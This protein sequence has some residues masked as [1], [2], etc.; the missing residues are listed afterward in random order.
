MIIPY[1]TDAPVYYFPF[2]TIATIATNIAFYFLFC[3]GIQDGTPHPFILDFETINPLQWLTSIFM[4]AHLLH[5]IGN[6]VFLWSY[7]LVIEG[8]VGTLRFLAI[9]LGIG[10]S[11]TAV[12]QILMFSLG[13]TGGSLG[14]SAAIFGLLGIAMLWAPKNCL[15]C[16]Y[17]LGFYFH[18]TFACPIIIFGA[19]Q[20]VM[21]I[22]LFIL[23]EFSMSSAALH[24]MGLVAG[25]PVGL[26]MLRRN[27]VDC[28][29]WDLFSTYFGDGPK[30]SA[31]ETRRA[32][33][34]AAE[35]KKAKQQNQHHRQ[36][37][38]ETIQSALD[39]KN[40]V[41]A[42]K[43]VRNAHDELQQGKQ[44]PD[45]MLVSVATLFQQQKQWNESI[46]YLIEILRRFPA[47]QTVTTRV[48]LAQI[49]IQADERPRQAMSVLD[50]LPQP[51]PESLK[52]KVA[53]IR[54]IAETQIA[55]GAIEIELH[56]W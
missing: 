51:I 55:A 32:A 27:W 39:Q 22:F 4:H 42:L 14:A 36:Q 16:I 33:K 26:V 9:Y 47:A 56:D 41:V 50:K 19:I 40:A 17:V 25:I 35:A 24:L 5:L 46:P 31:S 43:L 20:V 28:E 45:K 37:V 34:D 7:G 48:R 15:E 6:M 1:N 29:G 44:M 53:Q 12:E 8:K 30:E 38:L 54:K 2:G 49:L 23:A 52:S 18:G 21:E 3:L 13:Q 11:Q 10:V